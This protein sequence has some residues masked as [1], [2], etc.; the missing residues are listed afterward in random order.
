MIYPTLKIERMSFI[1][2]RGSLFKPISTL[3]ERYEF[4]DLSTLVAINRTN[5]MN[6]ERKND[7]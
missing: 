7:E 6:K 3:T 1:G 4:P 2:R 5:I